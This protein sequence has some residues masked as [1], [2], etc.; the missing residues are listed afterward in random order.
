[1]GRPRGP[2]GALTRYVCSVSRRY[3]SFGPGGT[4][5]QKWAR[6]T[7]PEQ[8]GLCVKSKNLGF[9]MYSLRS[10]EKS[11]FLTACP[12]RGGV[13]IMARPNDVCFVFYILHLKDS[14]LARRLNPLSREK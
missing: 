8:P 4:P 5:Q 9:S 7:S 12:Q 3:F 10:V 13:S 6:G 2:L 1:M 14:F 11:L